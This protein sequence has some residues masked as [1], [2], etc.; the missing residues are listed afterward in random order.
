MQAHPLMMFPQ[1]SGFGLNAS[2]PREAMK[3]GR[4]ALGCYKSTTT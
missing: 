4:Q 3:A 1:M 2:I